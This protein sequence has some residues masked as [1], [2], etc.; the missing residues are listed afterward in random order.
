MIL[1]NLGPVYYNEEHKDIINYMDSVYAQSITQ[2]QA[3]WQEADTSHRFA[4]GDQTIWNEYYGNLAPLRRTQFN[5]NRIRR[6]VDVTDGYQRRNRKSFAVVPRE[7]GD[8]KTASQYTKV[9]SWATEQD[10]ILYTISEAFRG[11]LI[12]G[13]NLL[14]IWMDYRS[15][16]I[17]GDIRVTNCSYNS[18][19]IDP[20]F[21]KPDLSDCNFIWRRNFLTKREVI[22]LLPGREEEILAISPNQ[23]NNNDNRFQFMPESYNYSMRQFLTYDEF[24]YRSFRTQ[25]MIVDTQTGETTEW[26]GKSQQDL[27][28][29][30]SFYPELTVI[31]QEIPTVRV[32]I[33]VSN[34]VMYD[35]PNPMGIDSY[36]FVPV[37]GYYY[38]ELPYLQ[39]RIQGMVQGL[40]DAQFLYNRRRIIELDILESQINSGYIYKENALVN[41]ADVFLS[42]QGKGLALKED[43]N[44]DD[45]RKI[46]PAQVPPSM[47]QLS[48]LLS[49]EIMEI[50]GVNEELL[51]SAVDDKAGILSML[52]QGAGLTT[53]QILFDQ[54]DRSQKLLGDIMLQCI[55]TNF[56]P[57]KVARIIEEQPQPQFYDQKFGKY[58]SV[59]E[60]GLNTATQKQMQ[61]AQLLELRNAGIPIPDDAILDAATIQNKTELL[62][63]MQQAQQQQAQAAQQMQEVQMAQIQAQT[64][65]AEA[66][67]VADEGLGIERISRVE[68]NQALAAERYG[69]ARYKNLKAREEVAS[70][71]EKRAGAVLDMV[72]ALKEI[73][74]M[75]LAGIEKFITVASLLKTEETNRDISENNLA[76]ISS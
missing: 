4:A 70:A 18:F 27:D 67:A 3:F 41:P 69:E 46:E 58:D 28:Y 59:V 64:K 44:M 45:V 35:G 36:P 43:A 14:Q 40:R 17:N 54:L 24:Y 16:P 23:G 42:G 37:L 50:S 75:D 2:N 52:R 72:K 20:F 1:P 48:E 22:A 56:T 47:I 51:G 15:D 6:V 29:F 61:F 25:Q 63:S 10:D 73:Q 74:Q 21:R 31:K 65:L 68:E 33:V 60:E 8:D 76:D 53:L 38:P 32:A 49:K 9:M 62:E 57:G 71:Q 5:F 26:K 7:N 39:Y 13:M 30:L 19:L 34:K 66:R 12:G 11:A 55:Q